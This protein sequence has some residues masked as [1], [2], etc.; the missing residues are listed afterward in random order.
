M[1]NG[2]KMPRST[3]RS[4]PSLLTTLPCSGGDRAGEETT[5]TVAHTTSMDLVR[6]SCLPRSLGPAPVPRR[7]CGLHTSSCCGSKAWWT[8]R[9]A[10]RGSGRTAGSAGRFEAREMYPGVTAGQPINTSAHTWR[11]QQGP[12]SESR[13]LICNGPRRV[14]T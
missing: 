5:T 6:R 3:E 13:Q 4:T 10:P 1:P 9:A 12:M 8:C 2:Q 14:I 7:R 11:N